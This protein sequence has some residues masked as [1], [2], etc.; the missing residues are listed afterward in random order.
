MLC[1]LICVVKQVVAYLLEKACPSTPPPNKSS[2]L[3]AQPKLNWLLP[4][5]SCQSFSGPTVS[6]KCKDMVTRIPYSIKTTRMLFSSKRMFASQAAREPNTAT[7]DST[8]SL[9]AST[10][11]NSPLNMSQGRDGQ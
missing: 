10:R 1:I 9:T 4:T 2:T 7:V 5:T 8:S 11:K 3:A 6:F